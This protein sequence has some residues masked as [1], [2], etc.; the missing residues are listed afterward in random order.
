MSL[1][2]CE[3]CKAHL[4][5]QD[6]RR[7]FYLCQTC[8]DILDNVLGSPIGSEAESWQTKDS[9]AYTPADWQAFR[10]HLRAMAELASGQC[11][12]MPVTVEARAELAAWYATPG[13]Y[14]GD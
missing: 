12:Y 6:V 1:I 3:R 8:E 7:S 14:T 11:H 10:A 2:R 13:R 5:A 9:L 4:T